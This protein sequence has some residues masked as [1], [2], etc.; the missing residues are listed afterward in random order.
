MARTVIP[1]QILPLHGAADNSIAW[2]AGDDVNDMYFLCTGREIIQMRSTSAGVKGATIISV[3]DASGRT[4]DV[5]LAP[6]GDTSVAVAAFLKPSD[7]NQDG[8][9][10]GRV[11]IDQTDDTDTEFAVYRI[12]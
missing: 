2:T 9:D 6:N 11:H 7:F 5:A 1:I 8:A 10:S 3:A 12:P 4:G